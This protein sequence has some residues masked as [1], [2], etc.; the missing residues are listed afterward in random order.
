V[1]DD[2]DTAF[3]LGKRQQNTT[4]GLVLEQWSGIATS[5]DAGQ[6]VVITQSTTGA[7]GDD[8]IFLME[9]SEPDADQVFDGTNTNG[10]NTDNVATHN[11][12]NVTTTTDG[13]VLIGFSSGGS[14]TYT[15]DADF[16]SVY[17]NSRST[18]A[19][20]EQSAAGV[21]SYEVTSS[22]TRFASVIVVAYEAG[23]AAEPA[24]EADLNVTEGADTIASDVDVAVAAS[25]SVTEGAD[26]ITVDAEVLVSV[27]LNVSEAADTMAATYE[28]LSYIVILTSLAS[29]GD[30]ITAIPDLEVGYW[31]RV[32]P[33]VTGGSIL[34]VQVNEDGTFN[35][36]ASVTSFEVQAFNGSTWGGYGTQY[37]FETIEGEL[38]VTEGADTFAATTTAAVE[39][40]LNVTEGVDT[41]T[42][43]ADV[44]VSAAL[45]VTEGSDQ[46]SFNVGSSVLGSLNVTEGT[47]TVAVSAEVQI[48]AAM[49]VIEGSDT[50]SLDVEVSV[51][52]S[53]N[54]TEGA[55]TIS[56]NAGSYIFAA[57]SVTEGADTFSADVELEAISASLSLTEGADAFSADVEVH[58]EVALS[59]TEG[60]DTAFFTTLPLQDPTIVIRLQG[61]YGTRIALRG[62]R[63]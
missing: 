45:N 53:L 62:T 30:R 4:T 22:P 39:A 58:V 5:V 61:T 26:T 32:G 37:T 50:A 54:V 7:S 6:N 2:G 1:A 29:S 40:S 35:V 46:A 18:I 33:V 42:V 44:L 28:S 15:V 24:I 41:I 13:A 9:I 51:A 14:G 16:T 21:T 25:L 34:D 20:L 36:D 11:S 19:S 47:D 27:A 3:G 23:E 52:A 57:M 10:A 60:A 55:D 31:L 49:S 59:V 48:L 38:T 63:G 43:D 12:G 56:V 8:I 17:T